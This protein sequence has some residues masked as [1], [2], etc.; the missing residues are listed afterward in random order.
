[1]KMEKRLKAHSA[2]FASMAELIPSVGAKEKEE[3]IFG[4]GP[5]NGS[6]NGFSVES[7]KSISLS[8]LQER[9]K[10]KIEGLHRKRNAGEAS[11]GVGERTEEEMAQKRQKRMERQKK[12]KGQRQRDKSA[13]KKG[14]GK[15]LEQDSAEA[16]TRPSVVDETGRVVFSKF[17]FSTTA[18]KEAKT[19]ENTSKKKDYKKLMAKAEA[20]QRKL[21]DIKKTDERR[22]EEL[23]KKLMWQKAVDMA[24]GTK[25]KDDPKMLKKSAKRIESKK[26]KSA[27]EWDER[28]KQ[29]KEAMEKRQAKRKANIDERKEQIR[30]K[31]MK[32]K[33]KKSK[34]RTPG[35]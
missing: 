9:L 25:L 31:K 32:K 22:G 26:K 6:M 1:M 15:N 18:R 19:V 21:E 30:S 10:E 17:D 2:L 23:A 7:V 4:D 8:A 12:K 20:A 3:D 34:G 28:K 5:S 24:R 11:R 13:K 29:E 14:N 33:G 27:K 35:F 16:S